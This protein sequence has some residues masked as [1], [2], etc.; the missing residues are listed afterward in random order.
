VGTR[1]HVVLVHWNQPV[2]CERTVAAFR[3]Q[4]LPVGLTIVDNGS[5][6]ADRARLG[7]LLPDVPVVDLDTNTGSGPAANAGWRRVLAEDAPDYVAVAPHDAL[8]EPGCLRQIIGELEARPD[9]GL[10][11]ADVGDGHV[12]WIDP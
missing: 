6:S 4:T 1:V 12:P 5:R 2:R 10:A 9:A 11:C 8:P 3:A 7:E